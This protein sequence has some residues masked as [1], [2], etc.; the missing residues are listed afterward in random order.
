MQHMMT[1]RKA[2]RAFVSILLLMALILT[3]VGVVLA[4]QIGERH[5]VGDGVIDTP[6]EADE[7]HHGE[8]ITDGDDAGQ[9]HGAPGGHLPAS[10][11][12]VELVGQL[13]VSDAV[14]GLI[15]DVGVLGNFA[16]LGQFSP[17]CVSDGGGGVYIID[18]SNPASPTQVGFIPTPGTFV[19]EGVQAIK[20][21]TPA[22]KGDLLVVNGESCGTIP[23]RVGGFSLYDVTNPASPVTLVENA[24]DVRTVGGVS[25]ANQIH[26][27]FAWQQGQQAYVVI[28]DDEELSDVDIFDI[29]DP[30]NP[31]FIAEV[32][33]PNWPDAQDAQSAGIGSFAASFFHDVVV[34]KVSGYWL[35]LLSYWDAGW[36]ILNVDDPANPV[37]VN[38][39]TYSDPDPETGFSPAEG[40]AHQAEWSHNNMFIIG[41]DEDFSHSRIMSFTSSAFSGSRA[42]NE[43]SF[44]VAIAS[45]P[46]SQMTGE[47]V[48]IGRGCPPG[49][50]A[51]PGGDPYLADPTGKIA[52]IQRGACRFDNKIAW[53]QLNGAVG[54]IVY[55]FPGA[56][57][58]TMGGNNP[59]AATI[60]GSPAV[61]GT[62][63]T[64]PA[65]SVERSTGELLRDGAPP[66]TAAAT[67][68]FNGWGYVHLLDAQTLAEIDTYA[69]PE[70]LSPANLRTTANPFG[71]GNLTVHEVATDIESNLAYFSYYAGGFRVATFGPNGIQED[72]HFIAQGGNDFWGVQVFRLPADP[73]ETTYV[74]ASD[75]DSGLWIFR[76][77]GPTP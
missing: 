7:L 11:L 28:V 20:V 1:D 68:E 64:I 29:T 26:S 58:F 23:N 12:N 71:F 66:V 37:F 76:Y 52:L 75:R 49:T 2:K 3:A 42:A 51:V 9:Q 69:I 34:K 33:L 21:N 43:G 22:F 38:D 60:D 65:V 18:I 61:F 39:S 4:D 16:Y 5:V 57:I 8:G 48:H 74:A 47:V 45:F 56:A 14:P 67:A 41:T 31:V 44:T 63:I 10:S 36:V 17:G 27:A 30:R 72:G 53:A 40:N 13:T 62:V 25:R 77:T 15:P 6:L 73:N 59:V 46:G 32:G 55:N 54:A 19:G 70:G 50:P 35:M 24:G